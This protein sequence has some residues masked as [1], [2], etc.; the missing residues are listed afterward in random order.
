MARFW[1]ASVILL[2]LATWPLW[3]MWRIS[4]STTEGLS[5]TGKAFYPALPLLTHT[6][7]LGLL[8]PW[9][10]LAIVVALVAICIAP[11]TWRL[12]WWI[13]C[14]ALLASFLIDQQRMQ[15]WAYQTFLYSLI[16]ATMRGP[17]AIR[18]LL[19]VT[20]S[21]YIYSGLG[22]LDYQFL[23]TL[24]REFL[25]ASLNLFGFRAVDLS[26]SLANY[27]ILCLPLTEALAGLGLL[28]SRTRI[29]ALVVLIGL[30]STLILLLGPWA[31]NHS[32]GVLLWNGILVCQAVYFIRLQFR[33]ELDAHSR[34]FP[35]PQIS[36]QYLA[37][38][39]LAFS[40]LA[41]LT[42]RFGK[43]DHWLSWSLYAAHTSSAN[44]QI[45]DSAVQFLPKDLQKYWLPL[46]HSSGWNQLNLSAWSLAVRK[47]PILPQSRYQLALAVKV[48]QEY[49]LE[50][51]SRVIIRG[52]ADRWTGVRDEKVLY[53]VE[54][55]RAYQQGRPSW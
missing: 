45:R 23:H 47:V 9:L 13:V 19:Y 38:S 31:M 25:T 49:H 37:V 21:I 2:M 55:M 12:L 4:G 46:A 54:A 18:W 17:L 27:L 40:M 43:W 51:Q 20:A 48:A 30:H 3:W 34:S 11:E 50:N 52:I 32:L 36:L 5:Q 16:F 10:S 26:E 14:G 33:D 28:F 35:P 7:P 22:K 39:V 15:P 53:G 42:E 8:L 1:S 44:L 24:G 6:E 41:P 29:A